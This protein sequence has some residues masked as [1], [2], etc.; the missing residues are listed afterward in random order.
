MTSIIALK[1]VIMSYSNGTYTLDDMKQLVLNNRLTAK[2]YK[3]ITGF[4]YILEE[5]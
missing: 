1:L 2:E 4:D 3:D 5:V